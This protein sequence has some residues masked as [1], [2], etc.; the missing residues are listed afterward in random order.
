MPSLIRELSAE[1][2]RSSSM[3]SGKGHVEKTS[4]APTKGKGPGK[5]PG[6]AK[7]KKEESHEI[8]HKGEAVKEPPKRLRSGKASEFER[9][10]K[11]IRW[12]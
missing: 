7:G 5:A 9:K 8:P 6:K 11:E 10:S 12:F 4:V 3:G 2:A 1:F